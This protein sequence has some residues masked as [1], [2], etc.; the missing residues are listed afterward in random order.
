MLGVIVNSVAVIIGSLL[1]LLFKKGINEKLSSAVMVGVGLCT[2]YIG[3]DGM[4]VDT[5][6]L[7]AIVSIVIGAVIGT[8]I[9]IDKALNGFGDKLSALLSKKGEDSFT[10]GFVA[11]SL[12]FCVG[13]MAIVGSITAGLTGD[14]TTLFTKSILDFTAA[15]MFSSTFGIGVVFSIIPLT[16]YQGLIAICAGFL[17]PVLTDGAINAI[18]CTGSIIIMG[19]GLNI[20]GISKFKI[21]NYL[22]A[23]ILAPFV[24]YLFELII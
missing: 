6:P 18:S 21:A 16:L 7:V 4:L 3:I 11:S 1:G 9:D 10:Q 12:L 15:I 2:I 22:P 19:L 13:A 24:Y 5:N 20:T 8:L 23:I 17:D 14:N